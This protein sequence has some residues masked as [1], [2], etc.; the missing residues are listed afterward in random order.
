MRKCDTRIPINYIKPTCPTYVLQSLQ[1]QPCG[2]HFLILLF[3]IVREL[4]SLISLGILIHILAAIFARDSISKWM[5]DL[6]KQLPHLN[7][8]VE[9]FEESKIAFMISGEIFIFILRISIPNN[10]RFFLMNGKRI[11]L[12]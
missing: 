11:I 3:K 6:D 8:K 2:T 12:Y 7:S 1:E 4:A 10:C 5:F 9:F